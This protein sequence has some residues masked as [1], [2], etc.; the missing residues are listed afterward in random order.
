MVSK[1]LKI[2]YNNSKELR[3]VYNLKEACDFPLQDDKEIYWKK[4]MK[5]H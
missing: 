4:Y 3:I 1:G 5:S 2:C